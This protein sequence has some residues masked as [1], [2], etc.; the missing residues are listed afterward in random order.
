MPLIKC[1]RCKGIAPY[2]KQCGWSGT[3]WARR[4]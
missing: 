1:P 4:K 2:C 3:I